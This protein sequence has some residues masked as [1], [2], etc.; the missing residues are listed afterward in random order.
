MR[1]NPKCNEA[2]ERALAGKVGEYSFWVYGG[3]LGE[4]L[5]N[6]SFH[7]KHK[8]D[9]EIVLQTKDLRILEVKGNSSRYEF[10]K[11]ELP[12]KAILEVVTDFLGSPSE[13]NKKLMN[14]ELVDVL[15]DALNPK[16][17][18]KV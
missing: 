11:N 10:K 7:L 13:K 17:E 12:P 2:R 1:W 5:K 18:P 3:Y 14:R 16:D 6:P 4:P 8:T 9:F 15:W